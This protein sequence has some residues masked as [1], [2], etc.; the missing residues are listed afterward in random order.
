MRKYASGSGV[1]GQ[2]FWEREKQR[3]LVFDSDIPP[4]GQPNPSQIEGPISRIRIALQDYQILPNGNP[5]QR[6][7]IV[8]RSN[9]IAAPYPQLVNPPCLPPAC[10][11][12]EGTPLPSQDP[13]GTDLAMLVM[14][15]HLFMSFFHFLPHLLVHHHS[16]SYHARSQRIH[17]RHAWG[18]WWVWWWVGT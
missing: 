2:K 10:L 3:R 17:R 8:Y 11:V 5:F 12:S 15:V 16:W 1:G 6:G 7:K 4:K 18:R 14:F 9:T 13:E